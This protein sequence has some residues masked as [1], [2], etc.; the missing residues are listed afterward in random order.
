[1][2]PGGI[3][4]SSKQFSNLP[5]VVAG[6]SDR[7]R[8]NFEADESP[9]REKPGVM[10]ATIDTENTKIPQTEIT[11]IMPQ[12]CA[13]AHP[14]THI[15]HILPVPSSTVMFLMETKDYIYSYISCIY[16]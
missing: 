9:P 13:H 12:A 6:G 14:R 15:L 16:P 1:M 10:V 4:T 2:L 3:Y 7:L 11:N 5:V 8:D